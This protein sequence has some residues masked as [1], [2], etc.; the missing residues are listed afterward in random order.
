MIN[1][2]RLGNKTV[3]NSFASIEVNKSSMKLNVIA[4]TLL[5]AVPGTSR[6]DVAVDGNGDQANLYISCI[7]D[8]S[9]KEG[10]LLSRS[11][12]FNSSS[13]KATLEQ[14]KSDLFEI[15]KESVEYDGLTWFKIEPKEVKTEQVAKVNSPATAI[16]ESPDLIEEESDFI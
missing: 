13:I 14:F 11:G 16:A 4:C 6:I 9:S 12:T 7:N 10:R 5:G 3:S 1:L 15:T 2:V 8:E